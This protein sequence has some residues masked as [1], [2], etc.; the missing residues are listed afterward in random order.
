M[1][2]M[3]PPLHR[4]LSSESTFPRCCFTRRAAPP[5]RPP[6]ASCPRT[7]E[8][9]VCVLRQV[10]RR[11]RRCWTNPLEALGAVYYTSEAICVGAAGRECRQLRERAANQSTGADT[12]NKNKRLCLALLMRTASPHVV[13]EGDPMTSHTPCKVLDNCVA[14]ISGSES[15]ARGRAHRVECARS[16]VAPLR[17]S[18]SL[19]SLAA[20]GAAMAPHV[21]H[22]QG[23][24][25]PLP[26]QKGA[27]APGA[28][29]P[30]A[31]H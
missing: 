9:R 22:Q 26:P 29:P 15:A 2:A 25:A 24:D 17:A 12:Q 23:G 14:L 20:A 11:R 3:A 6:V 10:T 5:V 7:T 28:P 18:R 31:I 27:Q 30:L 19:S 4:G 13:A 8:T 21:H 16:P 1:A